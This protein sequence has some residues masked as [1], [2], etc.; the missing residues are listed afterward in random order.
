LGFEILINESSSCPNRHSL[1]KTP[2]ENLQI[3]YLIFLIFQNHPILYQV[4]MVLRPKAADRNMHFEPAD[5]VSFTI[6]LLKNA[7]IQKT[8]N[9]TELL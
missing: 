6:K 3:R 9:A 4:I 8:V 5:F 7:G 1:P 2:D